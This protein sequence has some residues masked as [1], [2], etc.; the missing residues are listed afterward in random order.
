MTAA[1][2]H[3]RVCLAVSGVLITTGLV[4]AEPLDPAFPEPIVLGDPRGDAPS[5]RI[6]PSR[7]GR[8]KHQL[9]KELT[10]LARAQIGP[11]QFPP[12][13]DDAGHAYFATLTAEVVQVD[14]SC[15][16][17]TDARCEKSGQMRFR[18][19]ATAATYPPVLLSGGGL[20]VLTG[21]PA[22][23]FLSNRGETLATVP[24]SRASFPQAPLSTD[25]STSVVATKDGGVV[26]T[27]QRQLLEVDSTG[28][29][30]SR[31]TLPDRLSSPPLPFEGHFVGV[32]E[33]G[34]VL[35]LAP[36][37]EPRVLGMLGSIVSRTALLAGSNTILAA[38][39]TQK[40]L[41]FDLRSATTT[42]R[43]AD[44]PFVAGL[45]LT[46]EGDAWMLGFDEQMTVVR[47]DDQ[48]TIVV[49][50]ER[51]TVRAP[52][53]SAFGGAVAP[54]VDKSGDVAFVRPQRL[55]LIRGGRLDASTERV[56]ASPASIALTSSSK[57]LVGCRDGSIVLFGDPP[58]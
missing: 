13:L 25:A 40:L 42:V 12:V 6:D 47:S 58:E 10:E 30:L 46:S 5:E 41:S 18:L 52:S 56:C 49:P 28:R 2:T 34:F 27:S 7:T 9:P 33:A 15:I 8:S 23:V 3:H 55:A 51:T 53:E 48:R 57:L 50:P 4:N 26:L 31:T 14:V 11:F 16:G 39:T 24:L 29:V 19:G 37:K 44:L 32:S 21:A 43:A 1:W 38:G 35:E 54:I 45:A 36:P 17:R 20:A 22:L